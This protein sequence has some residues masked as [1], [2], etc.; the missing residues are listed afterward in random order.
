MNPTITV[1]DAADAAAA[2]CLSDGLGAYNESKMGY[3]DRLPLQVLVRDAGGAILGGVIGRTSLGVLTIE[4]VYLPEALRGC[5]IGTRMMGMAEAEARRR[6]C[7]AGVVDTISFQ[8]P[9]FY[10]RLGWR[11]LGEVPCGPEGVARIYLTKD[12]TENGAGPYSRTH[13]QK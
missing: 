4:K 5:D 1:S 6:G 7:R 12:F 10:L 3:V 11:I 2:Q 13:S 9:G 8:A